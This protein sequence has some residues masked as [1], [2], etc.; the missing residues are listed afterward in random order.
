M[1]AGELVESG[2]SMALMARPAHP[3]TQLLLSA[4]PDPLRAGTYDPAERAKLRAA[5]LDA[6]SCPFDGDPI[7]ACSR[8][9]PVRHHVGPAAD[10]HWVRC[11]LY[12]PAADVASRALA[13]D[14]VDPPDSPAR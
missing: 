13:L 7:R 4:V 6:D 11:H 12:R 3:Y 1:F 5:V 9:E 2:E 8:T 10:R 14:T